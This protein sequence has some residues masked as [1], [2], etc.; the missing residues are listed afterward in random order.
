MT[1]GSQLGAPLWQKNDTNRCLFS[2]ELETGFPG[3]SAFSPSEQYFPSKLSIG[4]L[5]QP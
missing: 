2:R 5:A 3:V 4:N 1:H